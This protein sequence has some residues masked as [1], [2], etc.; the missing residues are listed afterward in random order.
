MNSNFPSFFL[1]SGQTNFQRTQLVES[2]WKIQGQTIQMVAYRGRNPKIFA[3][4]SS[5]VASRRIRGKN[6]EAFFLAVK[7]NPQYLS[8]KECWYCKEGFWNF[9]A[10]ASFFTWILSPASKRFFI[11][12]LTKMI[13]IINLLPFF[14]YRWYLPCRISSLICKNW[15]Q[16][17]SKWL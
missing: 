11:Q 7:K 3:R 5:F 9:F 15:R 16:V 1:F 6:L 2:P 13:I 4:N 8:K 14:Y 12:S 10:F 17:W